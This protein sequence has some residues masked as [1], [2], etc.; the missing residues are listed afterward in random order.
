MSRL[1]GRRFS[2]QLQAQNAV[3]DPEA[4]SRLLLNIELRE[5]K[6]ADRLRR[7]IKRSSGGGHCSAM[8]KVTALMVQEEVDNAS[9]KP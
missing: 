2:R 7:T 5:D 4:S 1:D 3:D 8:L 9:P 6:A